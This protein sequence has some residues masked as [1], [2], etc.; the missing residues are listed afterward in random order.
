MPMS[1]YVFCTVVT[2]SH[3]RYA[4]SLGSQLRLFHPET[5][6]H[7]LLIDPPN[8]LRPFAEFPVSLLPLSALSVPDIEAMKIY[9]D[10]FEL[11]NALKPFLINHLLDRGFQKVIYL[12]SDILVVG[13]FDALISLLD[14]A[15]FALTPHILTPP[16]DPALVTITADRGVYN[17]GLWA[18]REHGNARAALAWLMDVL[19]LA[20]FCDPAQGMFVDQKLLPLAADL[21]PA[22]FAVIRNPGYNV[23]YWNLH[24]RT[25]KKVGTGYFIGEEPATFF[26]LSG[27]REDNP[28]RFS[29]YSDRHSFRDLPVLADVVADYLDSLRSDRQFAASGYAFNWYEGRRLTS[30]LRRHYFKKRSFAGYRIAR[31]RM[32]IREMARDAKHLF[33]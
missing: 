3:L 2:R 11:S 14:D 28:G 18:M 1:D 24:E 25:I 5:T 27:F 33:I 9:F 15:N 22:G 31:I 20:G 10:A 30:T 17:G 8:D 12:D 16:F 21:F 13:N 23:A 29:I 19:P 6:L 32:G 7:V 4:I 26:H